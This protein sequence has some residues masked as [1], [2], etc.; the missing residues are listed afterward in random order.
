[1]LVSKPKCVIT[2]AWP[3]ANSQ[4]RP[5]RGDIWYETVEEKKVSTDMA[6]GSA[7]CWSSRHMV[8]VVPIIIIDY[9]A[10]LMRF[11]HSFYFDTPPCVWSS[12]THYE[13]ISEFDMQSA[14][15]AHPMWQNMQQY[16][17]VLS[18]GAVIDLHYLL[19]HIIILCLQADLVDSMIHIY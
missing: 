2:F 11:G 9:F 16:V 1:M 19:H 7:V 3:S 15:Y 14:S 12:A 5:R 8:V 4:E 17:F 10:W 18:F 13:C 6:R